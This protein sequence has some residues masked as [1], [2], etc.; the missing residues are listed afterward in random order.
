MKHFVMYIWGMRAR[1]VGG[2]LVK[3]F[4][5][6]NVHAWLVGWVELGRDGSSGLIDC[7]GGFQ[8]LMQFWGTSYSIVRIELKY[9]MKPGVFFVWLDT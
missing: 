4:R 5:I 2:W 3:W 1:I 6:S 7:L 8:V 9:G